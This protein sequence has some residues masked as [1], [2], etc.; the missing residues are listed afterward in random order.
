MRESGLSA[1]DIESSA[2]IILATS[3][4]AI[5][6]LSGNATS[7]GVYCVMGIRLLLRS[8]RQSINPA[9]IRRIATVSHNGGAWANGRPIN[10]AGASDS[11]LDTGI[12]SRII[13]NLWI[14]SSSSII[15]AI[16]SV[17]AINSASYGRGAS[18]FPEEAWL[19]SCQIAINSPKILWWLSSCFLSS[20]EYPDTCNSTA[21]AS[22]NP[23]LKSGLLL[24][25]IYL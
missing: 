20:T 10:I 3:N 24:P 18:R 22:S 6:K 4:K 8:L 1:K 15:L 21:A 17:K 7:A 14:N 23:G 12:E 9:A 25:S 16:G 2:L 13:K 11:G 5:S 19:Y